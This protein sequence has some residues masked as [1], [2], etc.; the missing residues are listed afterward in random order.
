MIA[1]FPHLKRMTDTSP[2]FASFSVG[3][4]LKQL[5]WKCCDEFVRFIQLGGG[6]P[7]AVNDGIRFDQRRDIY[8]GLRVK[9]RH[10]EDSD[11]IRT[12][13]LQ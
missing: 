4:A 6:Y 1:P 3:R 2:H 9:Q 12:G 7:T 10:L 8:G 11:Q 13:L 5:P